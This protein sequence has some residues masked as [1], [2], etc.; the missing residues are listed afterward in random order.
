MRKAAL[1]MLASL[2]P[3]FSQKAHVEGRV[4]D[5][6]GQSLA[7]VAV[8]MAMATAP[9]GL[10][11]PPVYLSYSDAAGVFV[12]E[13][14]DPDRYQ[15]SAERAGY[16]RYAPSG[17][18]DIHPGQPLTGLVVKMT[19][20]GVISGRV[21]DEDG[22][23]YPNAAVLLCRW[24]F[25]AGRRQQLCN[26]YAN[27]GPDGSFIIGSLTAGRYYLAAQDSRRFSSVSQRELPG[28][29][30][31]EESVVTT[32]YPGVAELSAAAGLDLTAGGQLRGMDFRLRKARVFRIAGK[33]PSP[34]GAFAR[35]TV[36]L[37]PNDPGSINERT[38]LDRPVGGAFELN[39]LL[40]GSY[41]VSAFTPAASPEQTVLFGR[42]A[43]TIGSGSVEDLVLQLAP[44]PEITVRP[45]TEESGTAPQRVRMT[46]ISMEDGIAR[47][48]QQHPDQTAFFL[49]PPSIY[50]IT[51]EAIPEGTYVKSIRFGDQDVT[52]KPLDL[53]SAAGGIL[54]VILS[55]HAAG[56]SGMTTPGLTVT[57]W[58]GPNLVRT[59]NARADGRYRFTSLPPGEYRIAAWE[60]IDP[61]FSELPEFL[62]KF[63]ERATSI[64]VSENEHQNLD[65]VVVKGDDIEIEANKLR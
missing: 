1:L 46:L 4:T 41:I 58:D 18:I 17:T 35:T 45:R 42:Q 23:P 11:L 64:K 31:A 8:R 63:E 37:I 60:K 24:N 40:P 65:P 14:M 36:S 48:A 59:V 39:R 44:A 16:V 27:S 25:T 2:A 28:R 52:G 32:Y 10:L 19:P 20:E 49:V 26:A 38:S 57:L 54:D 56:V 62:A 47:Y 61:G 43:V 50:R 55:P 53:T 5:V 29:K 13:D 3:V 15:I 21:L 34:P 9:E 51:T 6:S 30:G 22:D 12:F 33:A 7:K